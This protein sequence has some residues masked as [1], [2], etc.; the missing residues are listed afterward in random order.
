VNFDTSEEQELLQE[1]VRQFVENE[2]PPSRVRGIF[3]GE[4]GHDPAF[5]KGLMELGLGG[6]VVPEAFG[7][8]GLQLI[9]LA[10]VAEVLGYGGAP[11]PFFGH[12]LATLALAEGGSDAQKRAWLPR[13]AAGEATGSIA[14]AESGGAWQPE[15]W[16]VK[17]DETVSGTKHFVPAA[18]IAD[19]LV[20]G[21][22]GGRLALVERDAPG[23]CT[24]AYD[25]VDRARR[26]ESAIFFQALKHQLADMAVALEPARGLYWYAAHAFDDVPED[27]ERTAALAKAHITDSA[28]QVARDA[29]EAHGGIG[30]TWECD[31][32]IWFKRI[33]L[34]WGRWLRSSVLRARD[35]RGCISRRVLQA[36]L[37]KLNF[38]TNV[39]VR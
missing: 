8:A 14:L 38:L 31:V 27:A 26:M 23:V 28:M 11:G 6:L 30:F 24:Q 33:M 1:T 10:L 22:A 18:S 37:A 19:L 12:A 35:G 36:Y 15:Q 9:D 21:C 39:P 2:C 17:A 20:V 5:W 7:G 3:D 13:L 25:G 4:T 34:E 16:Q 29:V 32:Q